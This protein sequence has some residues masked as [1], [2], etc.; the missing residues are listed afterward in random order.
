MDTDVHFLDRCNQGSWAINLPHCQDKPQFN[1][2]NP[3]AWR[4][5]LVIITDVLW[6]AALQRRVIARHLALRP[7]PGQLEFDLVLNL[8]RFDKLV[9]AFYG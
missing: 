5:S 9:R 3:H 2:D 7:P 1:I 6:L 4:K 8:Q